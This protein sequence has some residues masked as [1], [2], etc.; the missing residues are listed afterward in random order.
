MGSIDRLPLDCSFSITAVDYFCKL[1][2]VEFVPHVTAEN[3][4]KFVLKLFSQ[5]GYLEIISDHEPQF[6]STHFQSFLNIRRILHCHSAIYH[7]QAD[8]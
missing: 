1:P 5:E 2:E 8:G 4:T 3:I 7:P 6:R